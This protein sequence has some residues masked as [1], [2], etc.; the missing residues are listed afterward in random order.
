VIASPLAKGYGKITE[1]GIELRPCPVPVWAAMNV[2]WRIVAGSAI[3]VLSRG[4]DAGFWECGLRS[5]GAQNEAKRTIRVVLVLILKCLEKTAD[6]NPAI[7]NYEDTKLIRQ[8]LLPPGMFRPFAKQATV[9]KP[10]RKVRG[11]T[12][13][14]GSY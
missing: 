1:Q 2:V 12:Q 14:E 5:T 10:S 8:I 6:G 4:P 13:K 7:H 9:F 11:G 3:M